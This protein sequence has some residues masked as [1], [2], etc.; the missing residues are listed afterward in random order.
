MQKQIEQI[1]RDSRMEQLVPVLVLIPAV[2]ENHTERSAL[3][4]PS[5]VNSNLSQAKLIQ[6]PSPERRKPSSQ[7]GTAKQT[8]RHDEGKAS[9]EIKNLA[10]RA[11]AG[12]PASRRH[13][14]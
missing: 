7:L 11:R 12:T 6:K 4:Y 5:N 9:S 8:P 13:A 2:P 10:G 3:R 14:A 1:H